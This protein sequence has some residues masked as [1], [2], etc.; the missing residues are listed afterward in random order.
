MKEVGSE[1]LPVFGA[2]AVVEFFKGAIE[3]ADKMNLAMTRL[4]GA[5]EATGQDWSKSKGAIQ[6][7]ADV[8]GQSTKFS[9]AETIPA[10]QKTVQALGDLKQSQDIVKLAMDL[11]TK[12]GGDFDDTLK[13]LTLTAEGNA[14]GMTVLNKQFS[15]ITGGTTDGAKG[16]NLLRDASNGAS[17]KAT[18]LGSVFGRI[19][20]EIKDFVAKDIGQGLIPAMQGI[21]TVIDVVIK[22]IKTDVQ[23]IGA[24]FDELAGRIMQVI[25]TI[26]GFISGGV[27]GAVSAWKEGNQEIADA[28]AKTAGTIINIWKGVTDEQK[29][30][31]QQT[32]ELTLS[33]SALTKQAEEERQKAMAEMMKQTAEDFKK[34]EAEKIK[35]M[36]DTTKENQRNADLQGKMWQDL[37][38]KKAEDAKREAQEEAKAREKL[39]SEL[40]GMMTSNV[41]NVLGGTKTMAQG[42]SDMTDKMAQYFQKQIID[43]L[44]KQFIGGVLGALVNLVVPGGGSIVSSIMGGKASGGYVA[45]TGALMLHQGEYVQTNPNPSFTPVVSPQAG[46]SGGGNTANN[47]NI[48]INGATADPK[49]I[50]RQL[51][52]ELQRTVRGMGQSSMVA[53]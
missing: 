14:R 30:G 18:D 25:N 37:N 16:L 17:E 51:G 22:V 10:L 44:A 23:M 42:W 50:A 34:N 13:N 19:G 31:I 24:M 20:N 41:M 38:K 7:W 40:A 4:Q 1:L 47:I 11:T 43:W 26:S 9:E 12:Y 36:A 2:M 48:N 3:D 28:H 46:G 33:A 53:P 32:T 49:E 8:L 6:E 29:K 15:A 35:I 21:A 45:Q 5:V 39:T 52:M 27:K